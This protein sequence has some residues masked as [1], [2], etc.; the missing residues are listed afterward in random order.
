MLNESLF[1]RFRETVA[2][3]QLGV[4]GVHVYQEGRGTVAHRWRSD[5]RT[6]LYSASK[7]FA[8]LAVGICQEEGRLS[9]EDKALDFFP[10]Y[11]D[12]ASAGSEDI[13]L[14]DLLHMCSGK[15]F[16]MFDVP[17]DSPVLRQTDWAELFF[18]LHVTAKPGTHF[19]YSNPS[20]YL[21]GRVVECVTGQ[22]LRDYAKPRLFDKLNIFNPQWHTC[23]QGHTLSYS[24][25]YLTTEELSRLGRLLLDGGVYEGKQVVNAAFVQALHE[26]IVDSNPDNG[27]DPRVPWVMAIKFGAAAGRD[28]TGQTALMANTALWCPTSGRW[29]PLRAIGIPCG[30]IRCGRPFPTLW[31]C[32]KG[33]FL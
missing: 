24:G 3:Q 22:N 18:R 10:Q 9:I 19:W 28:P 13:T 6:C 21:L 8:A 14:R 31:S 2:Q 33:R 1:N 11:R 16:S 23:P 25:L 5:D 4:Y 29:L 30:W 12:I 15:L 27:S 32:C 17:W 20:T 26:D 7:T